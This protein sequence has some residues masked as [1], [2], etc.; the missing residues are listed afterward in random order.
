MKRTHYTKYTGDLASEIDLESLLQALSDYLLDSGFYDPLND[1]QDLDHTLDDLREA[2][3]RVLETGDFFDGE[4]RELLDRMMAEGTLD[5]LID[6]LME[7]MERENY[8]SAMSQNSPTRMDEMNGQI[9]NAGGPNHENVR[10]EVTDK[11][12][13]FLGFK[14]LRDLMGVAWQVEL[15]TPRHAALGNR[16]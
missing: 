14:T 9:G 3:R 8:I 10:F 7:R 16:D 13:D 11:S 2:L 12:L 15:W 6:K 1:F 4:T 5:E